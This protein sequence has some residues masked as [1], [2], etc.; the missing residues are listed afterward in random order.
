MSLTVTTWNIQNLFRP[1]AGEA[2]ALTHYRAKLKELARVLRELAPEVIALQ[3]VGGDDALKDLQ[4]ALNKGAS[5][6]EAY[7]HRVLGVPDARGIA[8]AFFSKLQFQRTEHLVDYPANVLALGLRELDDQPILR[9]GRGALHI[10]IKRNGSNVEL[11]N[12]HLKSKLLT[13]PGGKFSTEDEDLRARAAAQALAR[14][15]AEAAAI[16]TLVTALRK[17]ARPVILLGDLND[18]PAAASTQILTG[19]GGSAVGTR[20]FAMEDKGD[21][22]RLWNL[23]E[24]IPEGRRYSRI[25]AGNRELLDQI[26]V[27]EE[28]L[29]AGEEDRGGKAEERERGA[30]AVD[31]RIENL[32]SIGDDPEKERREL[33]P[34]HAAVTARVG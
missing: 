3:E 2:E 13:F 27:S 21:A 32:R 28:W 17:E 30:V 25:H 22:Q 23:A 4:T 8:C 1:A 20:G 14:R 33:W 11:I 18:G 6:S 29:V 31:T 12:V 16:R 26:L 34:D 5:A 10:S 15:G 7:D 9:L 24:L 19:P